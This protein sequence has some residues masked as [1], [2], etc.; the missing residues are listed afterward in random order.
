MSLCL[1]MA[2]IVVV[3]SAVSFPH[4]LSD[5]FDCAGAVY[6]SRVYHYITCWKKELVPLEHAD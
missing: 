1:V 4:L 3:A 2:V 6:Q 5:F